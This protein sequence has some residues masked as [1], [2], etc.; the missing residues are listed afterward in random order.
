MQIIPKLKKLYQ[1]IYLMRVF[2]SLSLS[3]VVF[4]SNVFNASMSKLLVLVV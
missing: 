2:M 1:E 3:K 4:K